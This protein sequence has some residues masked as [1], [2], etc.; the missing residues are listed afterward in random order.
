MSGWYEKYYWRTGFKSRL[1]DHLTPESYLE[2]MR[3]VVALLPDKPGQKIWDA[4]CGTGLLLLFLENTVKQG[5]V[6][7]GSDLL[8]AGLS[9]ARMRARDLGISDRVACVQSDI[10]AAPVFKGNSLDVV[11][12][13]FSIYTIRENDKRQQALKNMYRVLKPG[14][15][16]IVCCPSKNYDA[17][18][19]IEESCEL[20]RTRRGLLQTAIRR[21]FFYPLTKGLGLNF[22]QKQLQSGQW[23]SYSREELTEELSCAG[24]EIGYSEIIY[25]SGAYLMCGNKAAVLS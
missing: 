25:A 22:I 18:K 5:T 23:M 24:F 17:G 13:H 7:Y 3:K 2:S 11:V 21:M 9:Q 12:A 10:T 19:I 4:G 16:L 1:Y 6:Y 14:G 8:S 20:L 15:L